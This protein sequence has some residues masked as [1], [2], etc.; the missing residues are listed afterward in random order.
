MEDD[1]PKFEWFIHPLFQVRDFSNNA[2]DVDGIEDRVEVVLNEDEMV[3]GVG[4][5]LNSHFGQGDG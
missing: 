1:Y 4:T 3:I 5:L 2:E